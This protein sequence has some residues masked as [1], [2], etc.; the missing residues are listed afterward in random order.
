M[1][2]L[3]AV[4][5]I[6]ALPL[7]GFLALVVGGRKLGEP[8]AGWLATSA[9]GGA[10]L[11][12]VAVFLELL[13]HDGEERQHV[14]TLFEWVP[15]NG[16]SVDVAFLV[17][18]LSITMALF[19][20]GIGT[21]IHLYSIGYMHGDERFSKF[22]VYL[23]LFAFSMLMLVLADNFLLSFLGWEGVG[24]CSYFLI[25][26]WFTR[27]SAAVAGKKA[28]VTNR[29]GDFGFMVAMFL[30]FSTLGT[31]EYWGDHG[32]MHLAEE[33]RLSEYTASAVVLLLFVGAAG[34]SAQLPLYLWLPDA[35]EGPT[36]VSALIHAATMVTAGV[37][38][39]VRCA[40]ILE[41]ADPAVTL[42]I[43][44]IGAATALFAA[45]V[46]C[47][48]DD[49]KKVLA[50][51]TVSQLG[52]MVL[53]VGSGAY[54]A[55]IFHMIT[56]AFFKALLFL[57]AGS[58]IHGMHDEQDMKRMGALRKWMPITWATF[59]VGWLAISG[60]P[61]LSGFWSKDE[62]LAG[63]WGRSPVLWAV[64]VLVALLTAYYMSRQV[65]LVFYGEERWRAGHHEAHAEGTGTEGEQGELTTPEP[66]HDDHAGA[67]PH[68][69]PW[70]MWAPLAVLAVLAAVG[71][72]LN[73]PLFSETLFLEHW[74]EPS[75]GHTEHH[76][77]TSGTKIALGAVAAVTAVLGIGLAYATWYKKRPAENANLEPAILQKAW[78]Y[79]AGVAA[80]VGGPGEAAAEGAATFDRRV[81]D[82]AVN[83]L[84][85]L[86]RSGGDQL[87][88]VQTGY[89][90]N[91]ALGLTAGVVILLVWT[92]VRVGL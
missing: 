46:A 24:A 76:V 71:G 36:P 55:A 61:P 63:A 67:E 21:L 88:K 45:T 20:T 50:Y 78:G 37:F 44:G 22:F 23:N 38:L 32:V 73:L 40:P 53:A 35:M 29:I 66:V 57:G 56:H 6:P 1:D 82:G 2:L 70:V 34:K 86:V 77:L 49:I 10:F 87:R 4:W 31:L 8:A 59:L 5:L 18:P 25:S 16:F 15:V 43:A 75:L 3:D 64:G 26:F 13:S 72:L 48:Q 39:L 12:T 14:T 7:A 17:D 81:V 41:H 83:G 80:L 69:S 90:R 30:L 74:L 92:I 51:S 19:V 28:F 85:T 47:A 27:E 79:D 89:V 65:F 68:E 33:G 58:V 42:L 9:I 91:Y 11:A 84:A 62:I 60:V 52:Y 54:V